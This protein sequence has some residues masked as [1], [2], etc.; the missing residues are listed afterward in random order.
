MSRLRDSPTSRGAATPIAFGRTNVGSRDGGTDGAE[1][2]AAA[3]GTTAR[4]RACAAPEPTGLV[5][6]VDVIPGKEIVALAEKGL[7]GRTEA[8]CAVATGAISRLSRCTA[9]SPI[10]QAPS[11]RSTPIAELYQPRSLRI[12]GF[13]V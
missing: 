10:L 3:I 13:S 7:Q 4:S 11:V 2:F 6:C 5:G 9:S 8:S 1:F 12:E